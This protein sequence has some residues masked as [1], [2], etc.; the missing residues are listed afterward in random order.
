MDGTIR[1][2]NQAGILLSQAQAAQGIPDVFVANLNAFVEAGRSVTFVMQK[3]FSPQPGFKDWYNRKMEDWK[4]DSDLKYFKDLRTETVHI[5]PFKTSQRITTT[6]GPGGFVQGAGS[7]TII[8]VGRVNEH[9]MIVPADDK[10]ATV[11]GK[12]AQVQRE[13]TSIY[14]FEDRP[15]EN[16]LVLCEQYMKKLEELVSECL[17]LFGT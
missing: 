17:H 15:G 5:T 10:P 11:D 4:S 6:F 8:P 7:V 14:Q 13:T 1:K 9:G 3:D 16:A 12:E 2:L